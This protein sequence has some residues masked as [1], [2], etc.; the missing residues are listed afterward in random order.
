MANSSL[1]TTLSSSSSS[2]SSPPENKK[3]VR[4]RIRNPLE[5][6]CKDM[7]N[8]CQ[9]RPAKKNCY[10]EGSRAAW[11]RT[12]SPSTTSEE[13]SSSSQASTPSPRPL[14]PPPQLVRSSKDISEDKKVVQAFFESRRFAIKYIFE[15]CGSPSKEEWE[16]TEIV[17]IIMKV[18][19]IPYHSRRCVIKVLDRLILDPDEDM[20]GNKKPFHPNSV[21]R[22]NCG[23]KALI[24][25]GDGTSNVVYHAVERGLSASMATHIANLHRKTIPNSGGDIGRTAVTNF[26][27]RSSVIVSSARESTKQGST[28]EKSD[29]AEGR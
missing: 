9:D 8:W 1:T 10:L 26:I 22:E 28:D 17:T 29:W 24:K 16:E 14:G 4:K 18:L 19:A 7:K 5:F 25:D 6:N 27:K 21:I 3:V 11:K 15:L 2:S 20:E 13:L 12:S 23:R